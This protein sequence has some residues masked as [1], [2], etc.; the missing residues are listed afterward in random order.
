MRQNIRRLPDAELEV[1]QALWQCTPPAARADLEAIL[2]KTHPMAMTTLLTLLTR[3]SEKQF[4]S[5]E[6]QGRRSVSKVVMAM[7]WVFWRMASRSARTAGGVHCQSACITSSS[8]S[9][10]RRMF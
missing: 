7:G 9:G 8:A 6:K 2:Q 4:L 10:R 1:M 3:L 5:I